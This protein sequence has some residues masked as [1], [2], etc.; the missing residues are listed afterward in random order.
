MPEKFNVIIIGTGQAGPSMAQ[1]MTDEGLKVASIE[2]KPFVET[3]VNV[4]CILLKS[5]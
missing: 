3:C 1:R 2:R 4:G 5:L